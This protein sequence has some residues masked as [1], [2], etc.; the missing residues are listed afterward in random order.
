M[1]HA[2]CPRVRR[3]LRLVTLAC[4]A[5]VLAV[6]TAGCTDP[7]KAK[8]EHVQRGEA[9]L[10]ERKYQ[11]AALEFRNAIQIDDNLAAAHWGLAR[12]YEG[13]Q[14]AGETF[15]ELATTVRLDPSNREARFKLGTFFLIASQR[16]G[17]ISRPE[18][19]DEAQSHAE[20]LVKQD[21]SYI[22]GRVLLANVL[23]AR[24]KRPEALAELNRALE[25][26]PRRVETYVSLAGFYWSGNETQKAE[27]AFRRAIEVNNFASLA[28]VEYGKFLV[29][30]RRL[31]DAEAQFRKAVEV[32]PT[33]R[34]VRFVLA[35]FYLVNNRLED[36]EGAYRALAE[37]DR[38]SPEGR[39][40][41]ADFYAS[42]G[43]L[44]DAQNTYREIVGRWPEYARGFYRL[45][46]LGLQRGD[47]QGASEQVAELLK[48][49]ARDPD[50]LLLRARVALERGQTREAIND[51]KEVLN[52]EPRSQMA[53]YFMAEAQYRDGQIEQARAFAGEVERFHPDF[54]PAKLM[55]VQINLAGGN[56]EQVRNLSTELLDRLSKTAPGGMQTPQLL[57]EMRVRALTARGTA[58]VQLASGRQRGDAAK[59]FAAARADMEA[60]REMWPNAPSSYTNL[61]GVAAAEGKGD[62]AISLYE[63]ALSLDRTNAQALENLLRLYAASN[64]VGEGRARM[65]A[66]VGEQPNRAPLHYLRA[67]AYALGAGDVRP[68]AQTVE[69][70]LRR[71]IELDAD[72]IP[73]YH[74]LA[75]LY[76]TT[77]QLDRSVAEYRK[78]ADRRPND[79][80]A[81]R[82]I[83]MVEHG[84]QNYDAAAEN[85]RRAL[86]ADPNENIAAN[87]LAML[88]AEQNM[89]NLDE[90]MRLA[91]E[92]V[93]RAPDEPGYA[94]T[95]GWVYFKKGLYGAAAEQLQRAVQLSSARG[96]DNS[97][98]RYHL[99][100]ALREKGDRAAARREL[101]AALRLA[102]AEAKRPARG[103]T[104]HVEEA[105]RALE[106]M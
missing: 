67:V 63:R 96:A 62:E 92:V 75:E 33:N 9:F 45:G 22:P 2:E 24:G 28:Y 83:G 89:G 66:L 48:K 31:G 46:E 68:D 13:L 70:E 3:S 53:L 12:A 14:R 54:L 78:I 36:A 104:A 25:L 34:D 29:Q 58:N 5:L 16:D 42:V 15:D 51:L 71:T 73:A 23:A 44:D 17:Q 65:D 93:R 41:L 84:R 19:L 99:A 76:I 27:E 101:Q 79:A 35:S 55:Q 10:R 1:N 11:E 90:A 40:R 103:S 80:S 81:F 4:L 43:R 26:D 32:D 21:D 87:N 102:D 82:S 52:Q 74:R 20:E 59:F 60:A 8:A 91:Q 38:D 49:N 95:L 77:N 106:S 50:A 56:A 97:L 39:A 47:L 85:Y 57:N 64:R 37:L 18:F 69:A 7:A 94:D 88:Y 86:E 98:Y 61:A 100:L 6:V 72:F 105:R 30:Q